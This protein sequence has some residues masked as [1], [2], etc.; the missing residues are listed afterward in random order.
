ML[1]V[2]HENGNP[3][4]GHKATEIRRIAR[5]IWVHLATVGKAPKTWLKADIHTADHYK[6]EMRRHFPELRLCESD[7]K[8][9]QIAIEHYPSWH[10]NYMKS[11]AVKQEE[12]GLTDITSP[13]LS[14]RPS[15]A[16][17]HS[18]KRKKL[19]QNVDGMSTAYAGM[20]HQ[21][22]VTALKVRFPFVVGY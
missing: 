15:R 11:M 6:R 5:S 7:W 21:A 9:D 17:N 16:V 14:K 20:D 10:S 3:I 19:D 22:G 18:T 1:Y 13:T 4:D 8:A 12:P 2:E